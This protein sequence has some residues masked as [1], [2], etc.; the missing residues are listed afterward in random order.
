MIVKVGDV[1]RILGRNNDH[2]YRVMKP[3]GRAR[4]VSI[5]MLIAASQGCHRAGERAKNTVVGC[6]NWPDRGIGFDN[7][8]IR[9]QR[10]NVAGRTSR[11]EQGA[12]QCGKRRDKRYLGQHLN[13]RPLLAVA[14]VCATPVTFSIFRVAPVS[15]GQQ[16]SVQ[17]PTLC[18]AALQ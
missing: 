2:I 4:A 9:H 15:H 13:D 1:Q 8:G 17:L 14:V 6:I 16:Q 3:C 10:I 5:S 7:A 18:R 11:A 12:E